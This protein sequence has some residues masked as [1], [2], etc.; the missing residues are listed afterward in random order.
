MLSFL[1]FIVMTVILAV[2][3]A[4]SVAAHVSVVIAKKGKEN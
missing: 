1:I 2:F 3:A 4:L